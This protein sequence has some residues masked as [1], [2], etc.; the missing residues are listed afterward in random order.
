MGPPLPPL[1]E[2]TRPSP[3]R[4]FP[5][6]IGTLGK[7]SSS[8][9]V[10]EEPWEEPGE[11]GGRMRQPRAAGLGRESIP[12]AVRA[13]ELPWGWGRLLRLRA[14]AELSPALLS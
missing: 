12:E 2:S 9:K 6:S 11:G 4:G 13:G 14:S 10:R 3:K 8:S 5:I 1:A 7:T